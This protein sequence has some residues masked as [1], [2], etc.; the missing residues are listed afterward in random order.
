MLKMSKILCTECNGL[1]GMYVEDVKDVF[2]DNFLNIQWILKLI[3]KLRLRAFQSFQIL[4]ILKHVKDVKDTLLH[5]AGGYLLFIV[6]DIKNG[7]NFN[8]RLHYLSCQVC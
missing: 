6:K 1:N 5:A 3:F 4:C 7:A 2:A 8:I